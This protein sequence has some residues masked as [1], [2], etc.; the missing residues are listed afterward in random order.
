LK[1]LNNIRIGPKLLLA[2]ALMLGFAGVIGFVAVSQLSKVATQTDRIASESLGSVYRVSAI[3]GNAAQSRSAALEILTQLQLHFDSG[4]GQSTRS[5]SEVQKQMQANIAAY[6]KLISTPEQRELWNDV[7][8]KWQDYKK[9]QDRSIAVA[10]DGLAGDAQKILIGL[11]KEKFDKVDAAIH[12]LMDFSNSE[13]ERVRLAADGAATSA[14]HMVFVL[15]ALAAVIGCSIALLITRAITRPLQT[16]V[17]LLREIGDGR[18]D[19]PID[20]TG[21]DEVGELLAGLAKTQTQLLERATAERQR[22][23]EDRERAE[24]DRHALEEVQAMV[25]AVVQGHLEQR[26]PMQGKSGFARQLAESLNQLVDNVAGVVNDVSAMVARAN[27]GDLTHRLSVED[28]SGLER[29]I[30][31]GVNQLVGEMAAMVIKVKGAADE[32]ARGAAEI[33]QGNDSLSTRTEAQAASLEETAASMEQMTSTVRQNA[34]NAHQANQ[35]AIEAQQRAERGSAVVTSAVQAMDGINVAS[36]KIADIIGV[37]DEIAFQTNLLALNAAV[38]AARAGEQGRG[39][40]VVANEV[41][42]L[43][44]RSAKAAKEIKGLIQDSVRRVAEGTRVVSDSGATFEQLVGAVKQVGEIV[45][46]I[47]AATGEQATG[48]HQVSDAVA[49]MDELTQQNAALVEEAAAASRVLADQSGSLSEM[50]SRYRVAGDAGIP[51]RSKGASAPI[52]E[53]RRAVSAVG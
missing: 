50:M 52:D 18:L 53:L 46:R 47:A 28:R 31:T 16:T 6:Q 7:S 42:T 43:A 51:P 1:Y 40:A 17:V 5:L 35:L 11:A 36:R 26:L 49:K 3:G 27:G 8:A 21:R 23:G 32:V 13:A 14:R 37:I 34:D 15:L 4:S 10:E 33:S 45:A 29:Q 30:G 39:F 25:A 48:I 12:K 44:S 24:A 22:A 2:F 41:R 20:T 9:D 19:N 38:E